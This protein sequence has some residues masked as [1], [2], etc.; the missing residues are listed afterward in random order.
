MLKAKEVAGLADGKNE[1]K[2]V[3]A[4]IATADQLLD[5]K[6]PHMR[7]AVFAGVRA[8]LGALNRARIER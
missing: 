3:E 1:L 6:N 7:R 8:F 5:R 4:L 2:E